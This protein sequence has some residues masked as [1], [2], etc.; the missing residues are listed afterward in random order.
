MDPRDSDPVSEIVGRVAG[1][2]TTS[3]L[4]I[5]GDR[6]MR[7]K[8]L[9]LA[10]RGISQRILIV[11]L[12]DLERDGLVVRMV[13]AAVPPR[14][15]YELSEL[16][17][18]LREVFEPVGAWFLANQLAIEESRRRFDSDGQANGPR[19]LIKP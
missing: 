2:W 7:M 1:K 19:T 3:I 8:D 11:R 9:H 17:R 13:H 4:A 5:L 14:V 15:E 16:G 10:L 18:S 6:R 12:R